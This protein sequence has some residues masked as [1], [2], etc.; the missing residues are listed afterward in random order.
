MAGAARARLLDI[1]KPA[2]VLYLFWRV[3]QD[4]DPR[5]ESDRL[6]AP[7]QPRSGQK[8]LGRGGGLAGNSGSGHQP[9]VG[10]LR[11]SA[12]GQTD[13]LSNGIERSG[14]SREGGNPG[15]LSSVQLLTCGVLPRI[16]PVW[17]PV[18]AGMT[19]GK[20]ARALIVSG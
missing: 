17:I 16:P 5:D 14:H 19:K 10:Q 20:L 3:A 15:D 6:Y 2:C 18:F 11:A 9:I 7:N 4:H 8:Q 12:G 13:W 1:L